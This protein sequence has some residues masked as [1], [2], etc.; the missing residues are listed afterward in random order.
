M[1][2]T[3]HSPANQT[4]RQALPTSCHVEILNGATEEH[5]HESS[6]SG[7]G[8]ASRWMIS[9]TDTRLTTAMPAAL[10]QLLCFCGRGQGQ[11]SPP[12]SK[13]GVDGRGLFM[14]SL[15]SGQHVRLL[16]T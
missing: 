2:S 15:E 3:R 1:P 5:S 11:P 13:V 10:L 6:A 16:R 14:L 8:C 12:N 4:E 7:D 9:E